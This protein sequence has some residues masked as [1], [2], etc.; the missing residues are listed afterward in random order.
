MYEELIEGGVKVGVRQDDRSLNELGSRKGHRALLSVV[1]KAPDN[2]RQRPLPL[3]AP[4]VHV[5]GLFAEE[6]PDTLNTQAGGE[7]LPD[8]H[9]HFNVDMVVNKDE[10]GEGV[11]LRR[12]TLEVLL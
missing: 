4:L 9:V 2:L 12:M 3:F 10:V 1:E 11:A 7:G 8:S 6:Q 5:D